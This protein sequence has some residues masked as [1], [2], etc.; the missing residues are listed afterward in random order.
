MPLS[1]RREPA[2]PEAKKAVLIEAV[3]LA[4][5]LG[6]EVGVG[7]PHS[8]QTD[9]LLLRGIAREAVRQGAER[10]TIYDTNGSGDP[11][12]VRSLVEELRG[13]IQVP[14]FFHGHDDLGLATAN[15]LAAILAGAAGLDVTVN[16]IGDRA[17]NACL[18]QVVI[19][20][21]LRNRDCGVS[22][23]ALLALSRL[24]EELSGVAVSKLAPVVGEFVFAHR[25]PSHLTIP[26][27]FEA[28][29]PGTLGRTRRID[30][31]TKPWR[32]K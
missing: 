12:R 21:H 8:T 3:E 11:F 28:F 13:E 7:F 2:D 10:I 25:S 14:I 5:S 16:G 27:E 31:E 18:E 32:D 4:R 23:S 15:A 19:A 17:G 20:L 6:S 26:G 29:D 22:P 24:V 1:S 30:D 9:P